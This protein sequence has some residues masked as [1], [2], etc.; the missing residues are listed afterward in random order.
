MYLTMDLAGMPQAKFVANKKAQSIL[1]NNFPT[2]LVADTNGTMVEVFI[3]MTIYNG[4]VTTDPKYNRILKLMGTSA[5][6]LAKQ[7]WK[8]VSHAN[9][10]FQYTDFSNLAVTK[11]T[12]YNQ[13]FNY[14][15]D[16]VE[17]VV[18]F[19]KIDTCKSAE[20]IAT[21]GYPDL[22]TINSDFTN[23][24]NLKTYNHLSTSE[25]ENLE[26]EYVYPIGE[27]HTDPNWYIAFADVS[28]QAFNRKYSI[29]NTTIDKG[30]S[31][32]FIYTTLIELR[33][34]VKVDVPSDVLLDALLTKVIANDVFSSNILDQ[35]MNMVEND[36]YLA[37]PQVHI[38]VGESGGTATYTT[39]IYYLRVDAVRT[40]K[41]KN[42]VKLFKTALK[43]GYSLKKSPWWAKIVAVIIV[44]IIIIIAVILT[45]ASGG[46]AASTWYA[47][48]GVIAT[49]VA[50]TATAISVALSL[51]FE[52]MQRNEMAGDLMFMPNVIM[53][54]QD[55]AKYSGY[56]AMILGIGTIVANGFQTIA[57]TSAGATSSTVAGTTTSG[58][59][60][61][62]VEIVGTSA[63]TTTVTQ[64]TTAQIASQVMSWIGSASS[65]AMQYAAAEEAKKTA[66]LQDKVDASNKLLEDYTS[67]ASMVAFKEEF[68]SYAF[69]D[70]NAK[71]DKVCYNSTQGLIDNCMTKY[72][73]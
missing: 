72:Y 6:D 24:E 7:D 45:I 15:Q 23:G 16:S 70:L 5:T 65:I 37:V 41:L 66:E 3:P 58:G 17:C 59:T 50:L 44:I 27:V 36:V 63:V 62:T 64:M 48:A 22:T 25:E 54:F 18:H 21:C 10:N 39:Y 68:E 19:T 4:Y 52:A 55:I 29:K 34:S 14:T 51:Y 20:T 49:A 26:I 12:I 1:L 8:G 71:M 61:V 56:I 31:G 69:L 13:I 32:Q 67:P 35:N 53:V 60:S 2:K 11:P 40:M 42:F 9:F 57:T 38:S 47:V 28:Q 73:T 46:L 33:Y 30:V 43:F